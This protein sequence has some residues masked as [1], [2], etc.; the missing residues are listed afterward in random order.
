MPSQSPLWLVSL[1]HP[2]L[3]LVPSDR[4]RA[5]ASL[6]QLACLLEVSAPKPGNV[7]PGRHFEDTRYQDFLAASVAIGE[8]LAGAGVRS[9]GAT[10]RLAV[11]SVA[12]W[13]PSNTSLGIILM[14]AP[15]ARAAIL[16]PPLVEIQSGERR[17]RRELW[18]HL[19]EQLRNVLEVTTV[20][21]SCDV[22]AAIRRAAPGGLGRSQT[23]DVADEPD[24]SLVEVMRLA[25][26][27]DLIAREYSSAFQITFET[28]VPILDEARREGLVWDD[29]IVE[30]FLMLLDRNLDTHIIRRGGLALA[31][32]VSR[33]ATVAL[34]AGGV[35]SS[36]GRTL[37]AEMD[38][39]LRGP[40]HTANPGTTADLTAAA[41]FVTLLGGRW[42][43]CAA[44]PEC[45]RAAA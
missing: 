23:Q 12:Q 7:S 31:R 41:I 34:A 18:S 3:D 10:V 24:V 32:D 40:G 29:A 20:E 43:G 42:Q 30:T 4:A 33:R 1:Q 17:S 5:V 37:I 45:P 26:E 14:F 22:Y 38:A 8:P 39:A 25:A 36:E 9:V 16:S 35:R 44:G 19:R 13:T 6:A 27:R 2:P 28:A 11:E 15:L 21:D